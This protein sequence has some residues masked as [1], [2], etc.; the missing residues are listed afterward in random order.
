MGRINLKQLKHTW[1]NCHLR[2]A[3]RQGS[4]NYNEAAISR[5]ESND[6]YRG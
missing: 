3:P 5:D 6:D 1:S 2:Q 4:L